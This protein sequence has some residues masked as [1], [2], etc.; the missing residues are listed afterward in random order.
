MTDATTP[1][2]RAAAFREYAAEAER[3]A[4]EEGRDLDYEAEQEAAGLL[5]VA[6]IFAPLPPVNY[7]CQALDVAP[8]APLLIA[9]YGYSGKTVSAQDL[10][11]AVATGTMVWGRFPVRS[12]RVL[13][14]DYEQGTY[15]TCMRYQRLARARGIDPREL[16]GRLRVAPLPEWYLDGDVHDRL[17][18]LCK[19]VDLVIVDSFRAACPSTDENSSEAR[20]PLDRLLRVSDATGVTPAV[21]HHARKPIKDAQ[22]GARMSIRGSGALF[23]ACGAVLVFAAEKGAPITVVHEKAKYSGRTH[24]DFRLVIEDVEIDGDPTAGLRVSYL[25]APTTAVQTPTDRYAAV[26]ERVVAL[27]R[28]EGSV[29]GINVLRA[30]LAARKDDVS[31]AVAELVRAGAIRRGG[32]HNAPVLEVVGP[33]PDDVGTTHDS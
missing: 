28:A 19:G 33:T 17:A 13:H 20:V 12:G 32:T 1:A 16:E 11:L 29:G 14:I 4:A 27:I 25:A 31:A 23:D 18:R 8:G 21:I 15:L 3:R 7:L 5:D 24:E 26:K 10:A 6:N 2:E 9:G 30:R 22:G